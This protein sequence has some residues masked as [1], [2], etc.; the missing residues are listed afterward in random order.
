M[1]SEEEEQ[2]QMKSADS[3]SAKSEDFKSEV[4]G[5]ILSL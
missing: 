5:P 2:G 1:S 3:A 4:S